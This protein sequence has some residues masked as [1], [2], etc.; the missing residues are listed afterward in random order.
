MPDFDRICPPT[1]ESNAP[2][3]W[4]MNTPNCPFQSATESGL[5]PRASANNHLARPHTIG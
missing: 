1:G 4:R 5:V 2:N 3:G